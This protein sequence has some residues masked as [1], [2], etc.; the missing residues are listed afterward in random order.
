MFIIKQNLSPS[1][2]NNFI[3]TEVKDFT[4]TQYVSGTYQCYHI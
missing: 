1:Q 2:R 3:Q 4:G